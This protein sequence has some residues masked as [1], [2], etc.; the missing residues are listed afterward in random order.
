MGIVVGVY[1]VLL[2]IF[3]VASAL[4]VRH[5]VKY[6][7]LSPK[8][9]TIVIIFGLLALGV[10]IFSLYLTVNIFS[11]GPSDSFKVPTTSTSDI[12]F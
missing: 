3:L 7:Y 10:I 4:I 5:T 12:Q 9:K 1:A 8:F 11:G 2:I 6:G